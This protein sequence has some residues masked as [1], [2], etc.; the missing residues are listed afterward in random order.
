VHCLDEVWAERAKAVLTV[1]GGLE[2][3]AQRDIGPPPR[4]VERPLPYG[5]R[6]TGRGV[7][8]IES[9]PIL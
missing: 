3:T 5:A 8:D 1:A 2:I 7:D 9:M 6:P 4:E